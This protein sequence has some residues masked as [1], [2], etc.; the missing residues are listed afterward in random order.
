M[1]RALHLP[2][3]EL[4][5]KEFVELIEYK[6]EVARAMAT[7]YTAAFD[8]AYAR[9]GKERSQAGTTGDVV[10]IAYRM[11]R[12]LSFLCSEDVMAFNA[13]GFRVAIINNVL[14][15]DMEVANFVPKGYMLCKV[16]S[17]AFL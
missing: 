5:P 2:K 10:E 15:G 1:L 8:A 17:P 6:D 9:S 13:L 11:G 12:T 16:T 7:R 3:R 14:N 4:T